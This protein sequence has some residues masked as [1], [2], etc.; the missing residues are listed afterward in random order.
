MGEELT[1]YTS[2]IADADGLTSPGYAYQW[3]RVA[4]GGAETNIR[5]AR[6]STYTAQP[7]DVDSRLKVRVS[8]TD[9]AGNPETLTSNATAAVIVAQV[10]VRFGGSVYSATEGGASARVTVVLDKDPHRRLTVPLTNTPRGGA[11]ADDYAAPAEV[12]FNA[13]ETSKNVTVTA[14]DDDVDDDG[15]SVELS[16]RGCC[17]TG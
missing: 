12:V 17:Q 7:G 6:S 1:A 10:T 2:G 16:F 5:G 15:E 9:D 14:T 13:G 8:F 4:S 11:V 3:V